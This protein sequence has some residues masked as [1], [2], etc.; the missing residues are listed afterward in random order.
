[1][2]YSPIHPLTDACPVDRIR[3]AVNS[4]V[5]SRSGVEFTSFL[6]M[7]IAEKSLSSIETIAKLVE[8]SVQISVR[9]AQFRNLVDRVQHGGVVFPTELP[10]Y[11]R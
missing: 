9:L 8:K 1:M 2:E 11:L 10:S 5:V 3:E 7:N 4:C 6:I